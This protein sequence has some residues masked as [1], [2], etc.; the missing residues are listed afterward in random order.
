MLQELTRTMAIFVSLRFRMDESQ[1]KIRYMQKRDQLTNL[2]N[3]TAFRQ[4]AEAILRHADPNKTYALEYLDINNFGYV[5]EN[6]GYMVGD[7]IL[8]MYA[9]DLSEQEYFCAGCRLYSDFFLILIADEDQ[10]RMLEHLHGRNKRFTNMQNHKY[11]NSAMGVTAG[12]YIL[13]DTKM[14]VEQAIENA[15][16]AWKHA[17]NTGIGDIVLYEEKLRTRR[18]EE[19]KV[20]GEFFEALYRDDFQMY[21][22]P[23][24]VLGERTVYGAEALARWKRPDGQIL[25]PVGFID[26]LEKI[27]YITELDFLYFR[28]SAED[29]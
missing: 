4:A 28:G 12:V 6:Y 18:V 15:N 9:E 27:G 24:F 23:K 13:E 19:Q 7:D 11:P 22:Q 2:Y 1:A 5:N 29:S 8:K 20:I 17:K 10:D 21:L 3:Q 26:S 16:L 25:A 14:D